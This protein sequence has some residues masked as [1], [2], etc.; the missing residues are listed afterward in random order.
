MWI[1][2]TRNRLK[3][4]L[5]SIEEG[6]YI[7]CSDEGGKWSDDELLAVAG[8]CMTTLMVRQEIAGSETTDEPLKLDLGL[9]FRRA[10]TRLRVAL[11]YAIF[12]TS[13]INNGCEE[14]DRD[15]DDAGANGDKTYKVEVV[16]DHPKCMVM[17]PPGTS[18]DPDGPPPGGPWRETVPVGTDEDDAENDGGGAT[19]GR[20]AA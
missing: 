14:E 20:C 5:E 1:T 10:S 7:V 11:N 16:Y 12:V 15:D 17:Y 18:S 4:I 6:R 13:G 19:D 9:P 8:A 2:F 3:A